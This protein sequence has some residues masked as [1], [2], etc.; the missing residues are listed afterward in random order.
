MTK[1]KRMMNC[2]LGALIIIVSL[3]IVWVLYLYN[4][5]EHRHFSDED[6]GIVFQES[7][8]DQNGNGVDDLLDILFGAKEEA[9]RRPTYRSVYYDGGYPPSS[10]GVCTD[11]IWRALQ[12]AGYDLKT[13]VDEDIAACITCYPRVNGSP[14]P[15][16]DFRRVPNLHVFL[17]RHTQALTTDL[18]D[19]QAWQAGDIV[20]FADSHIGIVSDIRNHRGIPFLIHNGNL[21]KMEEDCLWRED[22]LKGISGHYRFLYH[23]AE[24]ETCADTLCE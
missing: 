19:I 7:G 18:D 17:R 9:K 6:F 15:N 21:P 20:V 3:I 13:M 2:L 22:F 23:E 1:K 10:E 14:D 8:R 16:I 5:I 4:I 11:V 12:N 24:A